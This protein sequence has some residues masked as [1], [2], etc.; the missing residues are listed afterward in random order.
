MPELPNNENRA[1]K[2]VY[3]PNVVGQH[4]L[5]GRDIAAAAGVTLSNPDPD[6]PPIGAIV[7]PDDPIIQKQDPSPGST[8][9]EHDSLRVWLRS[10]FEPDMARKHDIPPPSVDSAHA[11]AEKPA[12]TM[13]LTSDNLG[14]D[15]AP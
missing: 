13:D 12:Q 7:W 11:I 5:K 9:Y 10:D 2:R 8:A 1:A 4:F 3:V 15:T 6:G 14:D